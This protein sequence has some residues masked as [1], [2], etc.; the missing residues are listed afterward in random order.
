M[1]YG[2]ETF[3]TAG[4]Q[5]GLFLLSCVFGLPLGL[6]WDLFRLIR[7]V[8]RHSKAA[9]IAEDI[10]VMI[11]YGVYV[12]TFTSVFSRGEFR[13]FYIAG[14][15]IGFMMYFVTIGHFIFP[16][17]K[18]A[19]AKLAVKCSGLLSVIKKKIRKMRKK[20]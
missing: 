3:F 20:T 7:A 17:I 19:A 9:V 4:Q 6:V 14:N 18:K 1:N 12:S 11:L 16:H 8:F 10:L 5:T 2:L 13:F 15:F